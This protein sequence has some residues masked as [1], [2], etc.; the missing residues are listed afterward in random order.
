MSA[1]VVDELT[2]EAESLGMYDADAE[3]T[4]DKGVPLPRRP[5]YIGLVAATLAKMSVGDSVF[6]PA[7]RYKAGATWHIAAKLSGKKVAVRSVDGGSRVW[8]IK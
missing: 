8:R 2:H 6:L 3:L 7:T 4:I 1:T 5:D